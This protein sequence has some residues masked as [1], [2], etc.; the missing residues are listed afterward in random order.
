MP[1]FL[2]DEQ[3]R[4]W[5]ETGWLH[6]PGAIAPELV[7][8]VEGWVS[9]VERW[10]DAGTPGMHHWE[11][12]DRGPALARTEDVVPHHSRLREFICGGL[13][14]ELAGVLF[15][16]PALVFKEKI[17]YKQPGGA[18]FAPHQDAAAYRFADRHIS[19]MVPVD[20]ATRASGCL[21]VA[22]GHDRG[23]LAQDEGGRITADVVA[24]LEWQPVEVVP[25]DLL[26]FDSYVPHRSG[27]NSTDRPRRALYLTYNAASDG[28]LRDTYYE[29]KRREFEAAGDSF[30]GSRVRLSITDDFL[31]RPVERP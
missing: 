6:L 1:G 22:V 24:G 27:T 19:C 9:E 7:A 13:L 20:P 10:A 14:V 4:A 23:L 15:G 2:T 16:E 5:K 11:Q 29:D 31:G 25:G 21:D 26:W 8:E 30:D 18:G 28:D 12:T 17:N 3:L